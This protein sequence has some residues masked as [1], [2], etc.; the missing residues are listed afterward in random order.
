MQTLKPSL[1]PNS[2]N[3]QR[4][5]WQAG[6]YKLLLQCLLFKESVT[7]LVLPISSSKT[8]LSFTY[9]YYLPPSLCSFSLSSVDFVWFVVFLVLFCFL[10]SPNYS[11]EVFSFS[12]DVGVHQKVSPGY[13]FKV[14][15]NFPIGLTLI[16][17]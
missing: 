13:W 6:V 2:L 7:F 1:P 17:K 15:N 10:L 3:I 9:R 11:G 16:R 12:K 14:E 8:Y 5:R 4:T